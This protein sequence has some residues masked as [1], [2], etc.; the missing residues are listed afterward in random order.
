MIDISITTKSFFV[1]FNNFF[2]VSPSPT[3]TH[4]R[5]PLT[6][7]LSVTINYLTLSWVYINGIIVFHCTHFIVGLLL[8]RFIHIK[9]QSLPSLCDPLN[10]SLSGCSVHAIFQAR[11]LEWVATSSSSRPSWP[12]IDLSL[13][14]QVDSLLAEP[15]GKAA[16]VCISS[17]FLFIASGVP[18]YG[19]T[20]LLIHSLVNGHLSCF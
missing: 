5:Q 12:G 10:C 7:V 13:L 19:C 17:L 3:L 11:I 15:L 20:S 16:D 8:L 9:A 18:L 6:P 2:L 1:L 4:S 14:L